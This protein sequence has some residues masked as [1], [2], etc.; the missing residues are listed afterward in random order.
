MT[1]NFQYRRS[2]I[3][4]C[5]PAQFAAQVEGFN[6]WVETNDSLQF[7]LAIY[8]VKRPFFV[9]PRPTGNEHWPVVV[10]YPGDGDIDQASRDPHYGWID[11]IPRADGGSEMMFVYNFYPPDLVLRIGLWRML[12]AELRAA[13]IDAWAK[14]T[15]DDRPRAARRGSPRLEDRADWPARLEK[16]DEFDFMLRQGTKPNK[17]ADFVGHAL[18]TLEAWRK[19][20]DE[21]SANNTNN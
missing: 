17:A 21:L 15:A 2:D 14:D 10:R 3:I 1:A 20:R 9:Y 7:W 6:N 12:Y 19:R 16:L 18:R 13:G 5:S 11:V 8:R 4:T